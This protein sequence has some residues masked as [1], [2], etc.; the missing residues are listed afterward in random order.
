MLRCGLYEEREVIIMANYAIMRIAK[1]KLGA[2]SGICNHHERLK[3]RYKSNPDIDPTRTHLNYHLVEPDDKY[4]PMLLRRIEEVGAKRR[5]DSIVLQD[6]F[7]GASPGWI[8]AKSIEDRSEER[9]LSQLWC[10]W[11]RRLPICIFALCLS[12][13]TEDCLLKRL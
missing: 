8:K 1:R 11:M 9:I 10:I 7:I 12:R 6:C 2:V 3:E 4:R 13:K 5:K